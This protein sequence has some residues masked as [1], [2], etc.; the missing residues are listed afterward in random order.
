MTYFFCMGRKA[1]SRITSETCEAL[2]EVLCNKYVNAPKNKEQWKTISDNFE[3]LWQFPHVIEEIDG[4]AHS[5]L[6]SK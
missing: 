3:E 4:E 6:G 2:Y 1:V 5:H